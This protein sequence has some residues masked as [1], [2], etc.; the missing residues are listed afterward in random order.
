MVAQ[1]LVLIAL[2]G[3]VGLSVGRTLRT[4]VL[5]VVAG[6]FA[7]M[8]A[9]GVAVMLSYPLRYVSAPAGDL[10]LL[11]PLAYLIGGVA[12]AGAIALVLLAPRIGRV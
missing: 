8:A 10:Y 4:L 3:A 1:T 11:D 9:A 5:T 6:P 12:G 7:L 2:G